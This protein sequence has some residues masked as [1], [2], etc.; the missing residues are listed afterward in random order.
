MSWPYSPLMVRFVS[1]SAT[2]A[3]H[4]MSINPRLD[5][6]ALTSDRREG[7]LADRMETWK[8]LAPMPSWRVARVTKASNDLLIKRERRTF[9]HVL[10]D[11]A[12]SEKQAS[13]RQNGDL[14]AFLAALCELVCMY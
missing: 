2:N 6:S 10:S 4:D 7:L 8:S 1:H 14:T 3:P 11:E 12:E 9:S 5:P 13:D